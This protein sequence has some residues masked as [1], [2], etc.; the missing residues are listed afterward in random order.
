ML[1]FG[2][3]PIFLSVSSILFGAGGGIG[4]PTLTA[5]VADVAPADQR[6]PAMGLLRTMQDLALLVG[7][8]FTGVLSE[9]LGLGYQGGLLGCLAV[10]SIATLSF[11]WSVRRT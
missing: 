9:H 3:Q 10:L 8:F 1:A 6:G 5:Y 11:H 7:P 2:D 4:N